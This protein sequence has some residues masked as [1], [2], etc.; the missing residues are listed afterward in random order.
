[1]NAGSKITLTNNILAD[2]FKHI[3]FFKVLSC[4]K[5]Y[6]EQLK[7]DLPQIYYYRFYR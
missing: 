4:L 1:M 7:I 5:R 2:F 6:F 3:F